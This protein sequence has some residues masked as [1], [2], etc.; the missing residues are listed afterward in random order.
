MA[1]VAVVAAAGFHLPPSRYPLD[2]QIAIM[3]STVNRAS[4]VLYAMVTPPSS[5]SL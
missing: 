2:A 5:S 4:E 3:P 1:A